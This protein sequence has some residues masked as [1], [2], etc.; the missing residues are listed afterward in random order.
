LSFLR[1]AGIEKADA[2]CSLTNGDN[3]NLISAQVARKIFNVPKVITRIYDP[4]RA[5][6]YSALGLDILSGTILFASMVR[7]KIVESHFSSYLIESKD[8][9]VLEIE[10]KDELAGRT[11]G[12][13]NMPGELMVVAL[14]RL[15]GIIIPEPG[16]VAM[17]KTY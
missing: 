6:I 16:T 11:I 5:S 17:K 13:I 10:V 8:I 7:D 9:G 15:T 1:Q 3:T 4:R 2:F 14:R 12:D